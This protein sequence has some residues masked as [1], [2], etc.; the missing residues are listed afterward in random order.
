MDTRPVMQRENE[1]SRLVVDGH[2]T[3]DGSRCSLVMVQEVTGTWAAYPHGV[4]GLGVRLSDGEAAKVARRI[5]GLDT[6]DR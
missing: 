4:V 5:L 3:D 6:E 2:R 1:R